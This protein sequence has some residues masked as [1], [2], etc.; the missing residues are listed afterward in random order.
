LSS[1]QAILES[2]VPLTKKESE[3]LTSF[4]ELRR[5]FLFVCRRNTCRSPIAA[6]I[7]NAEIAARLQMPVAALDPANLLVLSAGISASIGR[8]D[9]P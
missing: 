9:D 6:A 2:N 4:E 8:A 3:V 5:A 1:P 7:G